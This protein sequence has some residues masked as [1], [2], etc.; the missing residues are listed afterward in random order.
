MSMTGTGTNPAKA[1]LVIGVT[2]HLR[3]KIPTETDDP[4]RQ[5][6]RDQVFSAIAGTTSAPWQEVHRP[7]RQVKPYSAPGTPLILLTAMA[8]G[9]DR[10]VTE[11]AS[12]LS[13]S[14]ID[15]R[16]V[17]VLPMARAV[18]ARQL[19]D[20][21][22]RDGK[23]SEI[24]DRHSEATLQVPHLATDEA[25]CGTDAASDS[26]R[27]QQYVLAS[28]LIAR[29]SRILVA[30]WDGADLPDPQQRANVL[31]GTAHT[32]H[33]KRTGDL[34]S[35][36]VVRLLDEVAKRDPQFAQLLGHEGAPLE[37]VAPG[38][39]LWISPK[40][41]AAPVLLR[42][43]NCD[44]AR[45]VRRYDAYFR[46]VLGRLAEFNTEVGAGVADMEPSPFERHPDG[47]PNHVRDANATY[48]A[49]NALA[50]RHQRTSRR[51]VTSIHGLAGAS[52]VGFLLYAHLLPGDSPAMDFSLLAYLALVAFADWIFLRTTSAGVQH[53]YWDYRAL[54][55]A[56]RVHLA[57][58]LMCIDTPVSHL[59][60][61]RQKSELD[62]IRYA[63]DGVS[64]MLPP[65]PRIAPHDKP[66]IE[67]VLVHW[68][69]GQLSFYRTQSRKRALGSQIFETMIAAAL[70]VSISTAALTTLLAAH[71]IVAPLLAVPVVVYGG[72]SLRH[73]IKHWRSESLFGEPLTNAL[74]LL[75]G[76][77]TALVLGA[78]SACMVFLGPELPGMTSNPH[79]WL[80][81][82]M[83]TPAVVAALLHSL[84]VQR[85]EG[86]EHRR[87]QRM[88]SVYGDAVHSIGSLAN[89][90][91]K[92]LPRDDMQ[93]NAHLRQVIHGISNGQTR[94]VQRVIRALGRES[95][96]EHAEWVLLHRDH[97]LDLPHAQ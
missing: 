36:E 85:A 13:N 84:V 27:R 77:V 14:G 19:R 88:A 86:P 7:N 47:I 51:I 67:N 21:E 2:G 15:I 70:L 10:L 57:W 87:Y 80:V 83:V 65:T 39:I 72:W 74:S 45:S 35:T 93:L 81:G 29:W 55:E 25:L 5:I 61:R 64:L 42:P 12:D 59:Y 95:L 8:D 41:P 17:P 9:A 78:L 94:F 18:Y 46:E 71:G 52:V 44:D 6:I 50:K 91:P 96:S 32:V 31:G 16:I 53:R 75:A 4:L 22:Y 49:A 11:V 24:L 38:P 97:P 90:T 89:V 73:R 48:A 76:A 37:V 66:A 26:A 63:M 30:I 23:F 3:P 60:L 33:M 69:G 54:A 62:W 58:R 56:L 34:G 68:V 20:A 28:L 79:H 82:A 1:P 92:P 40:E 43:A